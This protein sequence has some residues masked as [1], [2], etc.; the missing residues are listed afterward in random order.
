MTKQQLLKKLEDIPED[1]SF[2]S[3]IILKG[4]RKTGKTPAGYPVWTRCPLDKAEKVEVE[5]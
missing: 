2:P 3:G 5:S 4:Y 1:A